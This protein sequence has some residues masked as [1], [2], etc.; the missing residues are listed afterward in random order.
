MA[1]GI[2]ATFHCLGQ[3]RP[4]DE[5]RFQEVGFDEA[6]ASLLQQEKLLASEDLIVDA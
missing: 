5:I 6:H 2:S 1:N 4:R 3:L